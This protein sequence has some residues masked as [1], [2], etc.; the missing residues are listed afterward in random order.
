MEKTVRRQTSKINPK[1]NFR[2][3]E[4][5][6]DRLSNSRIIE[7][8][9]IYNLIKDLTNRV[10]FSYKD[11]SEKRWEQFYLPLKRKGKEISTPFSIVKYKKDFFCSFFQLG[12][13]HIKKGNKETEKVFKEIFQ[14]AIRFI[15]FIKQTKGEIVKKMVP[16][17]FRTGKIKGKYI[18]DK[19]ISQKAKAKIMEDY[20]YHLQRDIKTEDCCS[21]NDYLNTVS[22]CYK[23][24]F[25][26]E[27]SSLKP[28]EMYRRWADRRDGGMLAIKN[29][30]SKRA[31]LNWY[32]S[33]KWM[34]SHPFEIVFSWHRHG[35][36]LYPPSSNN[37]WRYSL[38]VT[39]YAYTEDF[40]KMVKALINSKIPF[41][42]QNLEEILDYLTG[43]TYFTVNNYSD[44]SFSYVPSREH[45]KAYFKHIEWDKLKILKEINLKRHG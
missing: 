19:M 27:A 39:N 23:A 26:K 45:K 7:N 15:Q 29:R 41:L 22:I 34:G 31:F 16:Y 4:D 6:L 18:L 32:E 21:L 9:E 13:L 37:S 5:R 24:S 17:D 28:L 12:S 38:R 43:E 3:V 35:I 20:E 44:N 2:E 14:E 10:C 33:G 25:G 36:H 42:A 40:I 11:K 30:K 8:L 1:I